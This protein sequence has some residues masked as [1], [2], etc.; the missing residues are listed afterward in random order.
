MFLRQQFKIESSSTIDKPSIPFKGLQYLIRLEFGMTINKA[1][2]Q[3]IKIR[4]LDL[5][6]SCFHAPHVHLYI[7]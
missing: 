3:T 5:E 6:N 2:S 4:R 7:C 1:L